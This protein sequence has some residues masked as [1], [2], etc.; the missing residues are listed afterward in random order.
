M[1]SSIIDYVNCHFEKDI[2]N[3]KYINDKFIDVKELNSE[4]IYQNGILVATQDEINF[5]QNEIDHISPSNPNVWT[6]SNGETTTNKQLLFTDNTVNGAITSEKLYFDTTQN[7]IYLDNSPLPVRSEIDYLQDEIN[8]LNTTIS[9][10]ND[11]IDNI[12]RLL[13]SLTTIQVST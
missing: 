5:L 7:L 13:F 9:K 4:K 3:N 10:M 6:N 12:S 8:T 11:T 1:S 2:G